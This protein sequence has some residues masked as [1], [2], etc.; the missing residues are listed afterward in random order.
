MRKDASEFRWEDDFPKGYGHTSISYLKRCF[1]YEDARKGNICAAHDVVKKCVKKNR[2]DSFREEYADAF[3]LPVSSKNALPKALASEIGLKLWDRVSRVDKVQRKR[4]PAIQRLLHQPLFC[5]YIEKDKKY[6]L[7]DDVIVQGGT[8]AA[9]RRYILANGGR[10]V[11]VV[12]LAYSIGS[13]AIAP[14]REKG[15][16]LISKFGG[17]LFM[18]QEIGL[19]STYDEMTNS[20]A[21]YLLRFSCARNIYRK[22]GPVI[23]EFEL[24]DYH[25]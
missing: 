10:V 9:L 22:L 21:R 3:V 5:G 16:R 4:L 15:V 6:V 23:E 25:M 2:L 7:A 18:L 20:Q 19:A 8:I 14:T 1:G 11:A 17:S 12:A 13:H 24:L